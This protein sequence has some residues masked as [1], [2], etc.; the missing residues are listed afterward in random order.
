MLATL[1]FFGTI[2]LLF[3]YTT[4]ERWWLWYAVIIS[5]VGY[6]LRMSGV[7]VSV[8]VGKS[9]AMSAEKNRRPTP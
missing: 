4:I 1:A 8:V 5:L 6:E 7:I 9:L 3:K 2:N